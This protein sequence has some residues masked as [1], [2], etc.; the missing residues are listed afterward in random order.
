M[1]VATGSDTDVV[2]RRILDAAAEAFMEQGFGVTTVDD[3]ASN[4]N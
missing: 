4:V 1:T 2:K 3:I